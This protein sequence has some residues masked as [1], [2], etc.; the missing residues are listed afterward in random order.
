MVR[1]FFGH[2]KERTSFRSNDIKE[3]CVWNGLTFSIDWVQAPCTVVCGWLP[4][5][6]P[7]TNL[8]HVHEVLQMHLRLNQDARLSQVNLQHQTIELDCNEKF[9][10]DR[11]VLAVHIW[12]NTDFRQPTA[13]A[14]QA[15]WNKTFWSCQPVFGHAIR[16]ALRA[17]FRSH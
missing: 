15:I 14:L 4:A 7:S 6:H 13:T 3:W 8:D 10:H 2:E 16:P 11:R 5:S 17:A 9:M 12:C 1:F